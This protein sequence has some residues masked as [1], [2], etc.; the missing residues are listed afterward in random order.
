MGDLTT[1]EYQYKGEFKEN[2]KEGKGLYIDF[3]NKFQ[4]SAHFAN[5]HP[6]GEGEINFKDGAKF[7]G[8]F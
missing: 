2:K 6:R 5:N 3:V 7:K 1:R 4:L 8:Y